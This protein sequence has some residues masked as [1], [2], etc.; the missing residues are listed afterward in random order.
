MSRGFP[1]GALAATLAL[2]CGDA[3]TSPEVPLCGVRHGVEVCA[4]R[5]EFRRTDEVTVTTR[6]ISSRPI[7]KDGCATKL[8]GVTSLVRAFEEEYLPSLRCGR[9]VTLAEVRAK[10]T[11]IE[12]GASLVET[13]T[14]Q[15]FAFQ[16]YYRANVWL[17]DEEGGLAADTPAVS[18]IF[19]MFPAAK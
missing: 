14:F 18:G 8:V 17:L 16:G 12:P 4:D 19:K 9:G 7:L 11:R 2:A 15:S 3:A 13:L 5:A 1:P 6:N 10:M